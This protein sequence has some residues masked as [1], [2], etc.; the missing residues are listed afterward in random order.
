MTPEF[1]PEAAL[2]QEPSWGYTDLLIFTFLSL[3]C[4]GL[5]QLLIHGFVVLFG[6]DPHNDGAVI[7]PSQLLLYVL[8]FAVLYAII[9]LQYGRSFWRSLGWIH[10]DIGLGAAAIIGFALAFLVALLAVALH[11]PD[12]DTPM[13]HLLARRSTA[14]E[15]AIVGTTIAPLCEELIFRGFMQP[16]LVRS[17]GSVAG[18]LVTA[19]VFGTLH[20]AQNAFTWQSGALIT[21]AGIAFGWMRQVTGSTRASTCMHATY[22]CTFFLTF[23][24]QGTHLPN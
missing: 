6:I 24:A 12:V 20:L 1:P 13:K 14:I 2:R 23:F 15:F 17:L 9:K 11:T 22:N 3:V 4:I 5:G 16:V 7:L 19:A 21:L 8:L 18:I 10:S